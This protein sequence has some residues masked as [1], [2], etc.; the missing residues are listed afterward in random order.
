MGNQKSFIGPP[1]TNYAIYSRAIGNGSWGVRA[2]TAVTL[3]AGMA[4][5][6]TNT[7]SLV[8][9]T[10]GDGYIYITGAPVNFWVASTTYTISV[11]AQALTGAATIKFAA[12]WG[13]GTPT[14][15]ASSP[16]ALTTSGAYYSFT[17]TTPT[18]TSASGDFGFYIV[19]GSALVYDAQIEVGAYRTAPI[20]TTAAAA[21][22]SN[23]QSFLDLTGNHAATATSLT[24]PTGN[25]FSFNGSSNC[26]TIANNTILDLQTVTVG[27]WIKTNA[28][29]QN[30]FIFEKGLVNTQ[31]ALF[32][33]AGSLIWRTVNSGTVPYDTMA[34]T[35]ATY[36]STS[37]W[38]YVVGT[39]TTGTKVLYVNG[40][41]VNSNTASGTLGTNA[42][43]SKIGSYNVNAYWFNGSIAD[44]QVY[45]RA[46]TATEVAQN[47]NALRSRFGL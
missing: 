14:N 15:V 31:Y 36:L 41:Q 30:G 7:A 19:N 16:V 21:S 28:L 42:G 47:Y 9:W 40:V 34:V 23:T 20:P 4:P 22:R 24:Y 10:S 13:T 45:N 1:A 38:A 29:S 5:N 32:Q 26:I 33:E 8:T 35:S 18:G 27:A 25:T 39:Y 44:V 11:W 46:L 37:A 2:G 43:G 12:Y 17:F 6:N 3:N